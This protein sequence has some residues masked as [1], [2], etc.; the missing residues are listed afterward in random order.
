MPSKYFTVVY[1][2]GILVYALFKTVS[3]FRVEEE[4]KTL[5][6]R[7]TLLRGEVVG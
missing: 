4:E 6:E 5:C 2:T 1:V 7:A 3:G